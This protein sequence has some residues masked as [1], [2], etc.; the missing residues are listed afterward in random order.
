MKPVSLINLYIWWM[1][2]LTLPV[3]L[4][5]LAFYEWQLYFKHYLSNETSLKFEYILLQ[6]MS[7]STVVYTIA[8]YKKLIKYYKVDVRR[9]CTDKQ[10]DA[11]THTLR[12]DLFLIC[13]LGTAFPSLGYVF[14]IF[15]INWIIGLVAGF[16]IS[17][18]TKVSYEIYATFEKLPKTNH[19]PGG[20]T[21]P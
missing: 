8:H 6:I 17:L 3:T 5:Q 11:A 15:H 21:Y 13:I 14:E 10:I 12:S 19:L 2:L 16:A 9:F 20:E 18:I 7:A 1:F 4:I